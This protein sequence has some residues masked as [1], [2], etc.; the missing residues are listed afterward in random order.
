MQ[1]H[2]Q[3]L[4][5][6]LPPALPRL[7][8]CK[9]KVRAAKTVETKPPRVRFTQ[10][11]TTSTER[12]KTSF[13]DVSTNQLQTPINIQNLFLDDLVQ[14]TVTA[15][16]T[17]KLSSKKAYWHRAKTAIS[18]IVFPSSPSVSP[19]V[20]GKET[21]QMEI[22]RKS[23][24]KSSKI[25]PIYADRVQTDILILSPSRSR[26]SPVITPKPLEI[27]SEYL[28]ILRSR[29]YIFKQPLLDLKTAV[30][31]PLPRVTP[32]KVGGQ[33]SERSQQT[34]AM[35]LNVTP[36]SGSFSMPRPLLPRKP[37]RQSVIETLATES[38]NVES[39]SQQKPPS[40]TEGKTK[41]DAQKSEGYVV[42]GEAFKTIV[43]TQYET[44]TAV[45]NL[46]IS[47]CQMFG[48]NALNL[49]GFFLLNCPD[50]RPLAFQLVYLNL[51]FND[52]SSFP[53]EVF[54]LQN[55]QVLNL[56]NNPIKEI[57][58]EIQQLKYLRIFIIAF[59]LITT[60]PHGLFYLFH[61]E[62]L[63]VSY[64][65]L[66]FIPNE[67][68]KLRSLEKL[69]V[70]GN[71][72]T[73]FPPGILKLNLKQ[74]MFENTYTHP[75]LWKE[76]SLNSPPHLTQIA[77]LFFLK[78][79]LQKNY[80]MIPLKIQKLLKWTSRC[81]WC[82]GPKFGEGFRV[83]RSFD[84]FGV[85]HLPVMFHVCSSSCYRKAKESNLALDGTS[86]KRTRLNSE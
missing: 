27:Q 75:I 58:S 15:I 54:C 59:N 36:F 50:L 79:N 13:P 70:D 45:T 67:I 19:Q 62:K 49:K 51:S 64:N 33:S 82:C 77:S 29:T 1:K 47:N 83:I 57:P 52:I 73:S 10:D 17:P 65:D 22:A 14:K 55:L 16:S 80:H 40:P 86:G 4:R 30:P 28:H 9:K 8:L 5:R 38:E 69:I 68:Q 42:Y 60:L 3:L 26:P 72:L 2:P 48:R 66:T 78:N 7:S 41:I 43:A 74:I 11:E 25:E 76:N 56:R 44:L 53:T 81:D 21:S 34:T 20:L 37:R 63:D 39:V 35:V 32:L 61:L 18:S 6:P 24:R 31:S 84:I 71:D 23:R 12:D 46:A 85:T